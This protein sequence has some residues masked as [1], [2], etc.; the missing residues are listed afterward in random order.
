MDSTELSRIRI[1]KYHRVISG[2]TVDRS[3]PDNRAY[4]LEISAGD[5]RTVSHQP[6]GNALSKAAGSP[7]FMSRITSDAAR[8][9][10]EMRMMSSMPV[11]PDS[12]PD[13][14]PEIA[15]TFSL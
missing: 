1:R 12:V 13:V 3:K 14:S 6:P 4:R 8:I 11:T 2:Y 9:I 10:P 7:G 5:V 15:F